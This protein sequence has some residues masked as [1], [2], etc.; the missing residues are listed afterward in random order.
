MNAA[1]TWAMAAGV[2]VVA[3]GAAGAPRSV[4]GQ[5]LADQMRAMDAGVARVT[6]A[7]REG[8]AVCDR[9]I[10]ID[11][12]GATRWRGRGR[13]GTS[14]RTGTIEAELVVRDGAVRDLELLELDDLAT[15]GSVDLGQMDAGQAARYFLGLARGSDVQPALEGAVFAA[16]IADVADL[17][18]D[19]MVIARDR[20]LESDVRQAAVFW[21]GQDAAA[22]VSAGIAELASDELEDQEVRDAA[23]FALSRRPADQG[24]SYLMEIA[25]SA[26]EGETRRSAMFWLAQSNDERVLAFFEEILLGRAPR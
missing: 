15:P 13:I 10:S 25:R 2:A 26:N 14:C 22:A 11:S 18:L 5:D 21:L 4:A 20:G 9:G 3:A 1:R 19:L 24:V 12:D 17:W 6:Y 16:S 8:V 23:V 7:I